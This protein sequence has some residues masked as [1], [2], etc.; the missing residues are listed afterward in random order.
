MMICS[1]GKNTVKSR[2]GLIQSWMLDM[3]SNVP[4]ILHI[5]SMKHTSHSK[6][7]K[8]MCGAI[9]LQSNTPVAA[10]QS[11]VLLVKRNFMRNNKGK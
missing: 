3:H 10:P 7:R 5:P 1:T 6:G 11:S 4:C 8:V 9:R 2:V